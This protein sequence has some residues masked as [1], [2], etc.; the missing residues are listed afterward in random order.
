MKAVI[1]RIRIL[2]VSAGLVETAESRRAREQVEIL[3]QRIVVARARVGFNSVVSQD[4]H[5]EDLSGLTVI[6][7]LNRGRQRARQCFVDALI[8]KGKEAAN[9]NE[10]LYQ[11]TPNS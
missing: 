4:G 6:D 5:R 8:A 1:R 11:A 2:E 9:K 7:I 3:H 10:G